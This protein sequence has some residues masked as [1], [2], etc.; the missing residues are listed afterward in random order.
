MG[1]HYFSEGDRIWAFDRVN[2]AAFESSREGIANENRMYGEDVEAM[3]ANQ[4]ENPALSAIDKVRTGQR[5]NTSEREALAR[6]IAMLWK[7]V[8]RGRDRVKEGMPDL[9]ADLRKQYTEAFAAVAAD[10]PALADRAKSRTEELHAALD[11]FLADPVPIWR[12]VLKKEHASS[13]LVQVLLRMNWCY[14]RSDRLQFLTCDNPVFFF[15]SE[16]IGKP[17]SELT[18]PFSDSVTLWA[19]WRAGGREVIA[20]KPEVVRVVN[21]RTANNAS[22]FVYARKRE[23]WILPFTLKAPHKIC[24]LR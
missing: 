20:A 4:I 13:N 7:R 22:R 8:P 11:K 12:D 17:E 21:R 10:N 16:G 1:D 15:E 3:L 24:R 2:S 9:A 23:D 6:Y 14:L 5:L 19:T 18:L